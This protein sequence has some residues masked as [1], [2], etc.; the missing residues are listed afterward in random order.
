MLRLHV[1]PLR[2]KTMLHFFIRCA[3][4]GAYGWPALL[5]MNQNPALAQAGYDAD[6]ADADRS[7]KPEHDAAVTRLHANDNGHLRRAA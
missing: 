5:T 3:L 6:P 1:H 2:E 4:T 7:G